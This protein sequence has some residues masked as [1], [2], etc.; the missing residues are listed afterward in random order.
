MSGHQRHTAVTIAA[1]VLLCG[2]SLAAARTQT[3]SE[4]FRGGSIQYV[5]IRYWLQTEDGS[6]LTEAKAQPGK[7]Y[8]VHL[9][10]N[11]AGFLMVFSTADGAELTDSTYPPYGGLLLQPGGEFRVPGTFRLTPDG[12]SEGL[13]FLFARSQTEM[14][15]TFDQ[16]LEKLARLTPALISETIAEGAEVGTY[17]VNRG[18][19]QPSAIIRVTR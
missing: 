3:A 16:A 8:S 11:V 15:R 13:V 7:Q 1:F 4:L 19:A 14:V 2:L 5:G 10:S 18:G 9:R 6:R 12:S 17:V